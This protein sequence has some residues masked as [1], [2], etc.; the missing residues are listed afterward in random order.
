MLEEPMNPKVN[1]TDEDK[2]KL[3]KFLNH[4]AKHATFK[5][6][7]DEALDDVRLLTFMQQVLLLKVNGHI[8]EIKRVVEAEK[9]AAA[10]EKAE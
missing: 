4:V 7:T 3:V 8:L 5:H 9:E 1:F 10:V 2:E 6:K